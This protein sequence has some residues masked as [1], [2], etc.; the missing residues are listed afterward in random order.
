MTTT[1]PD[2]IA[3]VEA[4][5]ADSG[6][7]GEALPDSSDRAATGEARG[8]SPSNRT[9]NCHRLPIR[10]GRP[11]ICDSTRRLLVLLGGRSRSG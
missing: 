7:S 2:A 3:V 9:G 8:A 1:V 4:G 11:V 6:P 10:S 5:G